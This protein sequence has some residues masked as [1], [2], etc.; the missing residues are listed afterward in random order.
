MKNKSTSQ[1]KSKSRSLTRTPSP[2]LLTYLEQKYQKAIPIAAVTAA[3]KLY[4][5]TKPLTKDDRFIQR[6]ADGK[7]NLDAPRLMEYLGKS[8]VQEKGKGLTVEAIGRVYSNFAN[9]DGKLSFEYLMKMGE[10]SGV[11]ISAKVAKAIVRKYGQRKD[12]LDLEDCLRLGERGAN[13][14]NSKSPNK[15]KK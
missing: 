3:H 4:G 9:H 11:P 7:G 12:Y 2:A 8:E 1:N 6:F 15:G 10:T 13:R 5:R 14:N